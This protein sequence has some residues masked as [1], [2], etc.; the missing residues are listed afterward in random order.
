MDEPRDVA[1]STELTT[2]ERAE[3]AALRAEVAQLRD[4]AAGFNGRRWWRWVACGLLFTLT[5]VTAISAVAARYVR[6]ELLDTDRYVATV[7]PIGADPAVKAQI[8]DL[9]TDAIV[10]RL[11]VEDVAEETLVALAENADRLPEQVAQRLPELAPMIA[12]G[13]ESLV[14]RVVTQVVENPEFE[15]LW[16]QVNRDA[17]RNLVAV[18]TGEDTNT[19]LQADDK[20]SVTLSLGP[21]I[22]R[23]KQRL[24]DRGVGIAE[25]LPEINPQFVVMQSADVIKAQR[26]V[27]ALNRAA[28]VLPWVAI[29]L[30]ALGVWAAPKRRRAVMILGFV[31]AGSMVVLGLGLNIGRS[32]YLSAV[33]PDILGQEAAQAVI[34]PVLEPLRW[35]LRAVLVVGLAVAIGGYLT[36]ETGSAAA[37]RRFVQQGVGRW[38]GRDRVPTAF[39]VWVGRHRRLLQVVVIVIGVLVLMSRT[40]PSGATVGW[41]AIGTGFGVLL[42]YLIGSAGVAGRTTAAGAGKS[43]TAPDKSGA[44]EE[45]VAETTDA[46]RSAKR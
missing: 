7:T 26:A 8:I 9:A 23:V 18:L 44:G 19:A 34:D 21:I 41:I 38:Q 24:T 4:G 17:H 22:E 31:V 42:V 45:R 37:I 40:Y 11:D 3:L 35:M 29:V 6:S 33:P 1:E 10:E 16:V 12:S 36:S 27:D 43:G 20:G 2:A 46:G 14:R 15:A 32:F 28:D 5:A 39:E 25:R 30:G 13:A